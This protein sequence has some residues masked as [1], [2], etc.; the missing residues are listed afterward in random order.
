M[1]KRAK[2]A[3][4]VEAPLLR[5]VG[6]SGNRK[7]QAHGGV[8]KAVVDRSELAIFLNFVP[9][10]RPPLAPTTGPFKAPYSRNKEGFMAVLQAIARRFAEVNLV[11][12]GVP[13]W[14]ALRT[15]VR[16]LPQPL[17]L[18]AHARSKQGR[19]RLLELSMRL[20]NGGQAQIKYLPLAHPSDK[21]N[22]NAEHAEHAHIGFIAMGLGGASCRAYG[23]S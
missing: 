12:Y 7:Y 19:G 9:D 6:L 3:H 14:R 11:T 23:P 18:L 13:S 1:P 2:R 4:P 8:P 16:G 21:R 10:F 20:T 15:E 17:A 22:F 5:Y